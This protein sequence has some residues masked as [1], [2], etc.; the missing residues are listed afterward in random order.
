MGEQYIIGID[1]GP[2][3]GVV[4]IDVCENQVRE[5]YVVQ[6]NAAAIYRVLESLHSGSDATG[7]VAVERF[8]TSNRRAARSHDHDFTRGMYANLHQWVRL[9]SYL[10]WVPQTAAH[11]KPWAT[12]ERLKAAGLYDVTHGMRHARDATRHA[13]FAG[14]RRGLLFDPLSRKAVRWNERAANGVSGDCT[15]E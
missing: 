1:P 12:D 3:P 14:V 9:R 10:R 11:V 7:Y 8:V 5:V 4:R 13:L 6:C 15:R 2:T